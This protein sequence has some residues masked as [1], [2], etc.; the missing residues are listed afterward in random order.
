[1]EEHDIEGL[2]PYNIDKVS[3]IPYGVKLYF[4]KWWSGGAV[5]FLVGFGLNIA[6]YDLIFLLG[7]LMGLCNEYV[8]HRLIKW[9]SE[10]EQYKKYV[11]VPFT[12]F[13]SLFVNLLYGMVL[14][15]SAFGVYALLR[16]LATTLISDT[17]I[18]PVEPLF[19]GLICLGWDR[20]FLLIKECIQVKKGAHHE[21]E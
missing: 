21:N 17:L 1:M 14:S 18:V 12:S 6:G 13:V 20:L 3:K 11:M 10:P 7:L 9:M 5:F 16:V 2:D 4:L 8:V 19:F 15:V